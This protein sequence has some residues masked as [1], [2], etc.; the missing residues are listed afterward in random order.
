MDPECS[1][2][3]SQEPAN[4][5]YPQTN[6]KLYEKKAFFPNTAK[7]ATHDARY[8][9]RNVSGF[10]FEKRGITKPKISFDKTHGNNLGCYSNNYTDLATRFTSE[11][12]IKW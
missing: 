11:T 9:L 5:P 4:G 8:L 12:V 3:H 1:L 2:P 10:S 6:T 7:T